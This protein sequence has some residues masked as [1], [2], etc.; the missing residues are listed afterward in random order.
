MNSNIEN[1]AETASSTVPPLMPTMT[2]GN[3]HTQATTPAATGAIK[4]DSPELIKRVCQLNGVS[5]LV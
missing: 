3:F 1:A 4:T 2:I 5:L